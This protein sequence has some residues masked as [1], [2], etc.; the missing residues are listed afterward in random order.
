VAINQPLVIP[1]IEE[2]ITV[3]RLEKTSG[4]VE[5]RKSVNERTELVDQPLQSEEVDVRRV[6]INR[7]VDKPVPVRYEDDTTIIP[8]FEEVLV[9]EKRLLLREEV[10]VKTVRRELHNPQEVTL[11]EERVEVVR[12]PDTD[13][14]ILPQGA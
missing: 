12:R 2:K 9:V 6:A 5:I 10:H 8:L 14:G 11:R 3:Q 4:I 7:F 1:V 13:Q